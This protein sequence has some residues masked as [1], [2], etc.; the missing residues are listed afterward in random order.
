MS[1]A[2][3]PKPAAGKIARPGYDPV[4]S[5]HDTDPLHGKRRARSRGWNRTIGLQVMSLTSFQTALLCTVPD[6][7]IEPATSSV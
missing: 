7:G 2:S 3:E 4:W 5:A 6:A 1:P